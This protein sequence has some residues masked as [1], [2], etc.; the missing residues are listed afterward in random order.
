MPG[1]KDRR[2]KR[3][4]ESFEKHLPRIWQHARDNNEK[5]KAKYI[6][7]KSIGGKSEITFCIFCHRNDVLN[8]I[9]EI[10]ISCKNR[11]FNSIKLAARKCNGCGEEYINAREIRGI[12]GIVK[13]LNKV[14]NDKETGIL[15]EQEKINELMEAALGKKEYNRQNELYQVRMLK[16]DY[17]EGLLNLNECV[18]CNCTDVP[19][20]LLELDVGV[21]G[22]LSVN[23]QGA[24]CAQ[25]FEQYYFGSDL[26]IIE[27]FKQL[28]ESN[29]QNY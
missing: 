3:I 11:R 16:P 15:G 23:V 18:F 6:E 12:E 5:L 17:K 26:K 27:N 28:I 1:D 21:K 7:E 4:E 9:I 20:K 14:I 22:I 8:Q 13:V 29:T 19:N 25:C 24:E 2:S 10:P